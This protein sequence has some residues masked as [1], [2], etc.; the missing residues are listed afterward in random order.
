[1]SSIPRV[2]IASDDIQNGKAFI[3]GSDRAHIVT[4]MRK[5]RGDI[6]C[7]CDMHGMTYDATITAVNENE[8]EVSLGDGRKSKSELPFTVKLYQCMPKGDKLDTVVCKAVELGAA[9]ICIVMSERCV[10]RP[11]EKVFAKR[12]ERLERISGSAAAQCGR[13]FI[14]PVRGLLSWESA[15]KEIAE[16]ENGFVCYEGDGTQPLRNLLTEQKDISFIIGPEGGISGH[17]L[18]SALQLGL[19]LAGLGKRIL[20]TE[21]A[22]A[23]VLSAISAILE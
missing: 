14:P 8:I 22:G 17:E 3:R 23:Y 1:M 2:Y 16:S 7:V 20:R 9:E 21:T 13:D 6:L 11:D 18:E 12:L 10:A 15:L 4:V 19:P 5:R